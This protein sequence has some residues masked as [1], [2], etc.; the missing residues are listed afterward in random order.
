MVYKK[1][2]NIVGFCGFDKQLLL[3][4]FTSRAFVFF[5]LRTYRIFYQVLL[6]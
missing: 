5:F 2:R 3:L 6:A 1:E 4:L